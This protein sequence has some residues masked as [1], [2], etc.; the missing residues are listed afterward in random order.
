MDAQPKLW[1]DT[2]DHRR[3]EHFADFNEW[4]DGDE[5]Q[6]LREQYGLDALNQPSKAFYAGDREAYEQA[7]QQYQLERRHEVLSQRYLEEQF[8]DDHWYRR[9]QAHLTQL[10]ERMETGQV[11]PF[12]GAG[13]SV[14]AGYPSWKGHLRQQGRTAGIDS[15]HIEG[16]LAE[17][18][19]EAIIEGIEKQRSRDVFVQEIRDVFSRAEPTPEVVWRITELFKNTVITTNYDRLI[20]QAYDFR[21]EN[22]AQII[23]GTSAG[24]RVKA[25]HV[26]VYKLHGDVEQPASCILGKNQYD[27]AYGNGELDMGRQIPKLLAYQYKNSSLLFL[28]SSLNDD[29]TVQVFRHIKENLGDEV[30]PQHFAIEQ[31]PEEEADLADRNAYLTR[32]GITPIWFEKGCFESV[33]SIL[34]LAKNELGHRGMFAQAEAASSTPTPGRRLGMDMDFSQFLGDFVDFMPLLHWFRQPVPQTETRKYLRAMQRVFHANSLFTEDVDLGLL[35]GID[36]LLRAVANKS[37][38]DDYSHG[39]LATAFRCFQKFLSSA[40]QS[41]YLESDDGWDMREMLMISAGQFERF[42]ATESSV[43]TPNLH[44]VRIVIA[45]L[46]HGG[47]QLYFPDRYCQLPDTVNAELSDYSVFALTTKLGVG[48]PDRLDQDQNGEIQRLCEVAWLNVDGPVN[49]SFLGQVK[50]L[51]GR[52]S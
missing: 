41:S 14:A 31:A 8:T 37:R 9:N 45:L 26:T 19:Y 6:G 1:C 13:I 4:L 24:D 23:N 10:V 11:V 42:I 5:G 3:Y 50:V 17:G 22:T 44:A 51:F 38:F 16:L 40:D 35:R 39:K 25:G 34:Q 20:E 15:D 36:N 12:V 27:Q 2:D 30:V 18:G 48:I 49:L 29:R 46:H 47:N 43:S 7:F 32:L 28:G 33:E 21:K 52:G